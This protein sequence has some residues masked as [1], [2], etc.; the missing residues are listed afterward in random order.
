[1]TEQPEEIQDITQTE[2]PLQEDVQELNRQN[3]P[4]KETVRKIPS[5]YWD[6]SQNSF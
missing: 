5:Q 6:T 1:M 3:K 2:Q 4:H